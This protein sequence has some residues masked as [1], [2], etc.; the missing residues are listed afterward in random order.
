[1][2]TARD[3]QFTSQATALGQE[4][5]GS[6]SINSHTEKRRSKMPSLT[7]I[8][9]AVWGRLTRTGTARGPGA[10]GQN[11]E[12]MGPPDDH[13]YRGPVAPGGGP[14][15][16]APC[17]NTAIQGYYALGHEQAKRIRQ[18]GALD[19]HSELAVH[20]HYVRRVVSK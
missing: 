12:P 3:I 15:P 11:P 8:L 2:I 6:F 7:A 5:T 16:S 9:S 14:S 18:H 1:M 4:I 10:V 19:V 17:E 20:S 13:I